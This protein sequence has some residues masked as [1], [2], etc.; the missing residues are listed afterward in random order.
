MCKATQ[1]AQSEAGMLLEGS[2]DGQPEPPGF[3]W[4]EGLGLMQS[5]KVQIQARIHISVCLAIPEDFCK[6][7]LRPTFRVS[8]KRCS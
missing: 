8:H 4:K 6:A 1:F 3:L 2:A 5:L 7:V